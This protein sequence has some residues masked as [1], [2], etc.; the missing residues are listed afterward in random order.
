MLMRPRRMLTL[1]ED[2]HTVLTK[3]L[4]TRYSPLKGPK[5]AMFTAR[6]YV[7]VGAILQW[8]RVQ[9]SE[10]GDRIV[11]QKMI[12]PGAVG[13]DCTYVRVRLFITNFIH[14]LTNYMSCSMKRPLIGMH[15]QRIN[16]QR[17]P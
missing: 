4:I 13:R 2:I 10:G 1:E 17:W 15:R 8:G 9:I 11:C 16:D 7:P 12:K 3:A 14:Y 6:K 5:I